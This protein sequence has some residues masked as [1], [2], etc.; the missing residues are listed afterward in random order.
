MQTHSNSSYF[1][2]TETNLTQ[3]NSNL[4]NLDQLGLTWLNLGQIG[5][6]RVICYNKFPDGSVYYFLLFFPFWLT[7]TLSH[8]M[9]AFSTNEIR[10]FSD[11]SF[12]YIHMLGFFGPPVEIY[13]HDT[14]FLTMRFWK[15]FSDI[16]CVTFAN[17]W[18]AKW[19]GSRQPCRCLIYQ[20]KLKIGWNIYWDWTLMS[21]DT[22]ALRPNS[23]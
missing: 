11:R 19:K 16:F 8:P 21:Y 7:S 22:V 15:T 1:V 3:L 17:S 10:T 9:A 12:I 5:S 2:K 6:T 23:S 18:T 4:L 13:G 20:N 14:C